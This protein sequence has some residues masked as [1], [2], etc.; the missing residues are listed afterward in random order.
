MV[1]VVTYR[2]HRTNTQGLLLANTGY[3]HL[4]FSSS[5]FAYRHCHSY[6]KHV[7]YKRGPQNSWNC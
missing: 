1:S 7:M 4:Y 6:H 5:V 3:T 2:N